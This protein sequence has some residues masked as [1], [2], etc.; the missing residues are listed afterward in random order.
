MEEQKIAIRRLGPELCEDWLYFF[1]E[2][3]F[4]DHGDWAFC[5]CLEGHLGRKTQEEWS[6][7]RE[8]REKAIELIRAGEMQGYLA[9]SGDSVVGWC[10]VNDRENYRYLTEMFREINYHIE[11]PADAK[12]KAIFCFLV[13]PEYRGR[14]VAQS[15]LDQV[16]ADAAAEGYTHVE[17]Y[18]FGDR[19]FAFQY[20]GTLG[21]YA[22]NG[23]TEA[24][25]L[26]YVKI[27]RKS[28][29]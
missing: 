25:D 14:G 19:N 18:P 27:M 1:D 24:D 11:E 7:P 29:N 26:K 22:R 2:I 28:L 23:F 21:M 15:L 4:K 12:V 8:R 6:D 10:N 20:H 17:A 16:C 9:Y 13:A 3:A 5:Y